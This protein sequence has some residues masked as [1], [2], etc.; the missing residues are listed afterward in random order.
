MNV[1][2][3][4]LLYGS[5]PGIDAPELNKGLPLHWETE[6]STTVLSIAASSKSDPSKPTSS[7]TIS[8]VLDDFTAYA[9]GVNADGQLGIGNSSPASE[10]TRVIPSAQFLATA[11]GSTFTLWLT[12]EKHIFLAGKGFSDKPQQFGDHQ[13]T[14]IAAFDSTVTSLTTEGS[15]LLWPDFLRDH[16]NPITHQPPAIPD[17][18]SCGREFASIRCG[19]SV[20]RLDSSGA[21]SPL[22]N[23]GNYSDGTPSAIRAQSSASYTLV[24][25]EESNVWLFGQIGQLCR[26]MATTPIAREM[27]NIFAMPNH[28]AFVNNL[29]ATF[30]FGENA[31]GQLGDGTTMTRT[32]VFEVNLRDPTVSVV[33]GE[34]FSVF[35]CSRFDTALFLMD[36]DEFLPGQLS[37][38]FEKPDDLFDA[39]TTP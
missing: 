39:N 11:C 18:I 8:I 7:A 33:G 22:I 5:F 14:Q 1:E 25:D 36:M 37:C 17:E 32:R 30:T 29:G 19:L 27:R 4:V 23:V 6:H 34:T 21:F 31:S 20:F 13:I 26:K 9:L 12:R 28:C 24:L 35:V 38:P 10:F 2:N 15:I 3:S 16:E